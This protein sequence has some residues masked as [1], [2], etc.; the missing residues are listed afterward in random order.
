MRVP[1]TL[2][3]LAASDA[4]PARALAVEALGDAPWAASML[5]ALDEALRSASDEYRA[6]VARD[7]TSLVG[8]I[9]FGGIA[10][11]LGAG[12][13]YFVAV[14]AAVR[15]R[16][17]AIALIEAA[18]SALRSRHARFVA[19]ELPEEPGLGVGRALAQR[20]RFRQEAAVSDYV[21]DG[22]G[23][24]LLRRDLVDT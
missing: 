21:R 7:A 9:V 14:D 6:L 15:R 24:V 8:L 18:C 10:G 23:L 20:A 22:V 19:I 4:A 1:V 2:G 16:G 13:I 5:A 3:P 12:R 17:I 11:A